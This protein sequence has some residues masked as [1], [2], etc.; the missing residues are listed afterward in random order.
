M[1]RAAPAP[2]RA[3]GRRLGGARPL[4]HDA[5]AGASINSDCVMAPARAAASLPRLINAVSQGQ[6]SGGARAG[7]GA[8]LILIEFHAEDQL[9]GGLRACLEI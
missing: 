1:S 9:L 3:S 6:P 5:R 4:V 2:G 7:L 8:K